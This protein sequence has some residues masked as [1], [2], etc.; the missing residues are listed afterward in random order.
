LIQNIRDFSVIVIMIYKNFAT[1][2]KSK[3]HKLRHKN[4]LRKLKILLKS[5]NR[6]KTK[7]GEELLKELTL[8][9]KGKKCEMIVYR[10]IKIIYRSII[11][12]NIQI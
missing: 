2:S 9:K 1:A 11:S 6:L 7:N 5:S 12:W 10:I 8:D 3:M 4:I